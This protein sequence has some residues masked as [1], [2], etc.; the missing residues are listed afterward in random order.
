MFIP[1]NNDE[2]NRCRF[3]AGAALIVALGCI[4]FMVIGTMGALTFLLLIPFG[5]FWWL[6]IERQREQ[7]GFKTHRT[8]VGQSFDGGNNGNVAVA[9]AEPQVQVVNATVIQVK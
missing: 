1:V 8:A 6:D 9:A 5:Y 4:L 3:P 7:Q 2:P